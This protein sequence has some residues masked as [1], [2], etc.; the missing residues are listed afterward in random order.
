MAQTLGCGDQSRMAD[1]GR[2]C[3]IPDCPAGSGRGD[4]FRGQTTDARTRLHRFDPYPDVHLRSPCRGLPGN[5]RNRASGLRRSRADP[6][7]FL[8]LHHAGAGPVL[9]PA[10]R[11][12][13]A[14]QR[15]AAGLCRIRRLH[16]VR[17]GHPVGLEPDCSPF[18]VR[19]RRP[20]PGHPD[21]LF[22][23]SACRAP[24]SPSAPGWW[25]RWRGWWWAQW[26]AV[27]G[28]TGT[29]LPRGRPRCDVG[30]R[31][32]RDDLRCPRLGGA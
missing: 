15:R 30:R 12:W 18:A 23:P 24:I 10:G 32:D 6:G 27:G 16:A 19:R 29:S 20:S 8:H 5:H 28:G 31:M 21:R 9:E 11:L 7:P 25:P 26:R 13:W 2:A 1:P 17:R 22:S 3:R 4:C 14:G